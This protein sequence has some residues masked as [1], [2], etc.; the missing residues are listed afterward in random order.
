MPRHLSTGR[1]IELV[2]AY[3]ED[4]NAEAMDFGGD[5]GNSDYAGRM[6]AWM[7]DG[8]TGTIDTAPGWWTRS[9][10]NVVPS[11]PSNVPRPTEINDPS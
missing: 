6:S 8:A 5:H 3:G 7:L 4:P 10:L 1:L 2:E 11:G 9:R